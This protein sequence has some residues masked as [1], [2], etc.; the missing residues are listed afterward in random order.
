MHVVPYGVVGLELV[1]Q[2]KAVGV[3]GK[4]GGAG[5]YLPLRLSGKSSG[6]SRGVRN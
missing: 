2:I 3:P 1:V 4:K 5:N 6:E